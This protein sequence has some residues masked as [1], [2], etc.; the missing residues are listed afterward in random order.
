MIDVT[1][2]E[3]KGL[4]AQCTISG[5]DG[6]FREDLARIKCVPFSDRSFMKEQQPPVWLIRNAQQYTKLLPEIALAIK[7]YKMQ[8][9]LPGF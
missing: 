3:Y 4:V 5:D 1:I 7:I 9:R 8:K 6:E 2:V